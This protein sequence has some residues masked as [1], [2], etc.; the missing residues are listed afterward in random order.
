ML[1][2]GPCGFNVLPLSRK[3]L[4]QAIQEKSIGLFI[5][6]KIGHSGIK[7]ILQLSLKLP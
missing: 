3:S 5:K 7:L 6:V 2:L 1:K 4:P